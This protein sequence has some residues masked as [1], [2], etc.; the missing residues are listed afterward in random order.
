M[1]GGIDFT[2]F[3]ESRQFLNHSLMARLTTCVSWLS[4]ATPAC[5]RLNNYQELR[6]WRLGSMR[7]LPVLEMGSLCVNMLSITWQG[8]I[9]TQRNGAKL[10][11][12]G[13]Y[14]HDSFLTLLIVSINLSTRSVHCDGTSQ[15]LKAL[16]FL[17]L[18]IVITFQ[19][20]FGEIPPV[21]QLHECLV[22]NRILPLGISLWNDSTFSSFLRH[23]IP[24]II[25]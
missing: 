5:W 20:E 8:N 17:A 2:F 22:K 21:L 1:K 24:E 15:P 9:H 25:N 7:T 13:M 23:T 11:L 3:V 12:L 6:F 18:A 14:L 4:V 19:D 16:L 10:I